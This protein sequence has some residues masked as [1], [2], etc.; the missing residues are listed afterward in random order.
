[1]K[2]IKGISVSALLAMLAAASL[3]AAE[4]SPASQ[5]DPVAQPGKT[6]TVIVFGDSITAGNMLP[7]AEKTNVW[8]KVVE[9]ESHGAL[10]LINEGKG[11]RPTTSL[12]EFDALLKRHP[13][14]DL[15]VIALGMNDSRDISGKCVTK[16]VANLRAM[17]GKCRQ[18]YG[19]ETRILLVGPSNINKDAL[20]PTKPIAK[21]REANLR[22]LG[23]AFAALAKELS[24]DSISLFGVVPETS[25]KADG[26]HPDR[27]GNS[28]IARFM[29]AKLQ[30]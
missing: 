7:D 15:L 4:K 6:R 22:Q 20:G 12:G 28:A 10:K 11:G 13:K 9:R 27:D 17:V 8:V 30:P 2:M 19:P 3:C 5:P 23:D 14:P 25:L 26:V 29:L 21:E 18:A 1:M 24:C 16:A